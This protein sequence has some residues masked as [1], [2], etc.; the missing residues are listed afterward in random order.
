MGV[1]KPEGSLLGEV[2][3]TG[4]RT[5]GSANAICTHTVAAVTGNRHLIHGFEVVVTGAVPGSDITVEIKEGTNVIWQSAIGASA[6]IGSRTGAMF[7]KPLGGT[8]G[9]TVSLVASAG[10][11]GVICTNSLSTTT[12]PGQE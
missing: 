1:I 8:S 12:V 3:S 7:S 11:S 5:V 6:A 10:G 4:A 2:A 9:G